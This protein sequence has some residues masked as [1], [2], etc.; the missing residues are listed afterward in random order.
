MSWIG[1]TAGFQSYDKLAK[2]LLEQPDWPDSSMGIRALGNA[3]RELDKGGRREWLDRVPARK[4]ALARVLQCDPAA[5]DDALADRAPEVR[6]TIVPLVDLPEARPL[7]LEREDLF[8]GIPRDVLRPRRWGGALWWRA[9]GGAGKSLVGRWLEVRGLARHARARDADALLSLLGGEQ[10]LYVELDSAT[11]IER[12]RGFEPPEGQF[13]CVAAPF[14]APNPEEPAEGGLSLGWFGRRRRRAAASYG[15][16]PRWNVVETAPLGNWLDAL[17]AW[18]ADRL[19]RGTAFEPAAARGVVEQWAGFLRTPGDV[20][21]VCGLIDQW[22]ADRVETGDSRAFGHAL[23]LAGERIGG[24][25]VAAMWVR[26]NVSNLFTGLVRRLATTP[27]VNVELGDLLE[28]GVTRTEWQRLMPLDFLPG[29]DVHAV[30]EAARRAVSRGEALA[31][32]IVL[33]HLRPSPEDIVRLLVDHHLLEG[34]GDGRLVFRM[35]WLLLWTWASVAHEAVRWTAPELGEVALRRWAAPPLIDGLVAAFEGG[36]WSPAER[37]VA[38]FDDT[39]LPCIAALEICFRAAGLAVLQGAEISPGLAGR[40]WSLQRTVLRGHPEQPAPCVT[41]PTD[42]HPPSVLG[43][44]AFYLAAITL[45]EQ[46]PGLTLPAG[47][48]ALAPWEEPPPASFASI[49]MWF[50]LTPRGGADDRELLPWAE[51]AY[52]LGGR[53]FERHGPVFAHGSREVLPIQR[54]AAFIEA[55]REGRSSDCSLGSYA[56]VP[57][58]V[59]R[60]EAERRGLAW[61]E[62]L[63]GLWE[64]ATHS[65]SLGYWR[66]QLLRR[67]PDAA[68]E[69]WA[70]CPP[71]RIEAELSALLQQG[72]PLDGLSDV[73][74]SGVFAAL[75]KEPHHSA[76]EQCWPHLPW[77]LIEALLADAELRQWG[78]RAYEAFWAREP[79]RMRALLHRELTAGGELARDLIWNAPDNEVFALLT[80]HAEDYAQDLSRRLHRIVERRSPRW[81]EAWEATVRLR[82][83]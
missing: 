45:S 27:D 51:G 68:A 57:L 63:R 50:E 13:V 56:D 75:R 12:L 23:E 3:L 32:E 17:L 48:A 54:P 5:I 24:D 82:G 49:A 78:W 39:D 36:D 28:G 69:L 9:Y 61:P 53:L 34:R 37:A 8:P 70:A 10:P 83:A 21:T 47:A 52:A 43:L 79:D 25:T 29:P 1:E 64:G 67:D 16:E 7:D 35:R 18:V 80:S 15:S 26:Q 19:K 14:D 73:Q 38:A 77:P 76:R 74:W 81:R 20:L 55:V 60:D 30:E 2:K 33:G 22:G 58:D 41:W 44:G 66:E 62:V 71:E 4:L 65:S 40:L 31:P 6:R 59:L 72:L 11:G 42:G 46:V